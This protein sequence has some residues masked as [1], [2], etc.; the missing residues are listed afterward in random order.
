MES[1]MI[2]IYINL[3][4]SLFY[5]NTIVNCVDLKISCKMQVIEY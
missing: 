3:N 2:K 1:V 4:R 5:N